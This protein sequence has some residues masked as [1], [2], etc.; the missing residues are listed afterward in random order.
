MTIERH[1][2]DERRREA[3]RPLE[4]AGEGVSE[5]F[6][7]A[8]EELRQVAEGEVEGHDPLD[9]GFEPEEDAGSVYGEADEEHSSEKPSDDFI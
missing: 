6:E 2:T 5:G 4:E 7:L 1:D 9:D 8:E 3:E